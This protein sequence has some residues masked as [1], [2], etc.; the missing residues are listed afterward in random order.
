L[1]EQGITQI[2]VSDELITKLNQG[3]VLI[4]IEDKNDITKPQKI[5]YSGVIK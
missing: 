5:E 2:L 1:P 3:K 4:S